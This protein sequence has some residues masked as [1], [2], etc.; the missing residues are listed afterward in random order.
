MRHS[1]LDAQH[2][3]LGAR[4]VPF[5]GWEM[6]L[7]YTGVLEEHR[8]CREHGVVFDVSHLGTIE[9]GGPGAFDCSQWLLTQRPAQD[10]AGPRAV[11]APARSRRRARRR[12]HH[13]VVGRRRALLRDAERVEHRAD[14]RRVRRRPR[15]RRRRGRVRRR[16][17]RP[18]RS[19]RCRAP[20]R[21]TLLAKVR[22][23]AAD[24]PRFAVRG[25]R[26][27]R[28]GGHGLHG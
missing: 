24:V 6:P 20:K 3:A 10:R 23:D 8:A 2:R 28:R 26:R 14:P 11:H 7:Q 19:S 4:M 18:A 12:R 17:R 15:A 9:C 16:H 25:R 5:G 22:P 13:R 1:P 27:A 21:A